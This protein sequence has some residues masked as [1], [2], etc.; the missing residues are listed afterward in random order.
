VDNPQNFSI[1]RVFSDDNEYEILKLICHDLFGRDLFF[2]RILLN[3]HEFFSILCNE[4][5]EDELRL[6]EFEFLLNETRFPLNALTF[7]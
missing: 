7:R 1:M 2:R 5:Y 4:K 6:N 3:L